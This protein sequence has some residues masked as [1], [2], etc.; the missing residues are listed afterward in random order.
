MHACNQSSGLSAQ[1]PWYTIVWRAVA[2][3]WWQYI[4]RYVL[5]P[6]VTVRGQGLPYLPFDYV[7]SGF[8]GNFGIG[9]LS[10]QESDEAPGESIL[11]FCLK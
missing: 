2:W 1:G 11:F 10:E 5:V 4:R 8:D 3:P 6:R 9:G 7:N